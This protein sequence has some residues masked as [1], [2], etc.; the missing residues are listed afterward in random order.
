M[1][2]QPTQQGLLNQPPAVQP[3]AEQKNLPAQHE[4]RQIAAIK[5]K[6]DP[7]KFNMIMFTQAVMDILP[8]G[9]QLVPF[10]V[11]I[12]PNEIWDK[13]TDKA[14]SFLKD[15]KVML[16]HT[17][18][19]KIGM[20]A[21][22]KL[23]RVTEQVKQ[24]KNDTYLLIEYRASMLLPDG[25]VHEEVSGKEEVYAGAHA[26]EKIDTKAK[27]NA[28]RALLNIPLT[29]PKGNVDKPF[30]ILKPV[31][32]RGHSPETDAIIDRIE[33]AKRDAVA[34]LYPSRQP[35]TIEAKFEAPRQPVNIAELSNAIEAANTPEELQAAA[36]KVAKATVSGEERR[37]L[38]DAYKAR[39]ALLET[40]EVTQAQ[41]QGGGF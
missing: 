34:A 12:P 4:E 40:G 27:R 13:E 39:K 1:A 14:L 5:E 9:V 7:T 35:Q 23:E 30:V 36:D 22:V 37:V 18:F 21:G 33:G 25:T 10:V 6:F 31:F 15:G 19:K 41:E 38:V 8:P 20:A 26:R 16:A 17:A 3:A 24:V 29:M 32:H 2:T 28:I 11:Q